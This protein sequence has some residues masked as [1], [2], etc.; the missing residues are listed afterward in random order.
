MSAHPSPVVSG[1]PAPLPTAAPAPVSLQPMPKTKAATVPTARTVRDRAD[2]DQ[3]PQIE[4]EAPEAAAAA[5]DA[6]QDDDRD[7]AL[8][9]WAALGTSLAIICR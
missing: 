8:L 6:P 5:A 9:G 7:H 3:A 4:G 2:E 1:S